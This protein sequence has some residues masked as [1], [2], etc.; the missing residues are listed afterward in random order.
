MRWG[1]YKVLTAAFVLERHW[2][3]G[4]VLEWSPPEELPFKGQGYD[5]ADL[6]D[7]L[8][9]DVFYL[10]G[11]FG[12]GQRQP[13]YGR[14]WTWIGEYWETMEDDAVALDVVSA[15]QFNSS[16]DNRLNPDAVLSR[17]GPRD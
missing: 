3:L 11:R 5:T 15:I 9:R 7:L 8:K 6:F 13:F 17:F 16:D 2:S 14:C 12:R 10:A 4:P 1:R